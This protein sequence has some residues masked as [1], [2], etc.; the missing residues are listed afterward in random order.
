VNQQDSNSQ[1]GEIEFRKKLYLQQV[2]RRIVFN[3]EF[4]A[5]G[6]KNILLERMEK[7]SAQMTLLQEKGI[8][9][10]PYIEIGAERCQR[11]LVM[12]NDLGSHGAAVDISHDMLKSCDYYQEIFKKSK[13]PVRICCDA[14]TLPF[15]T[16]SVPFAFC[17]ETLHHFPQPAPITKE[18]HRVLSPGGYFF[19]DEEPYKQV[20]HINLYKGKNIYSQESLKRNRARKVLDRFFCEKSCN[21]TEHGIIE[22]HDISLAMWKEALSYFDE[23][24]VELRT[25]KLIQ[26]RL[27]NPGSFIKHFAA[28]LLGGNISGICQKS[29]DTVSE[30]RSIHD[31]L[32]C[33]S[34]SKIGREA[35][36][37]REDSW[38]SCPTC[39]KTYPVMDGVLLLF[40]YDKFEELYPEIFAAC[41]EKDDTRR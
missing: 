31:V 6:I 30:K 10:S 40:S 20:L 34:C 28:Y 35:P 22:N 33:P 9:L 41:Q 2:E 16:D 19:F 26:S 7:T 11:S 3:D 8:T 15:M 32:I 5:N 25:T 36:L 18:I 12:E 4:D 13:S 21:E 29:G 37:M 14:N 27:F 39:L 1:K 38:F 24:D 17:Y 23:K